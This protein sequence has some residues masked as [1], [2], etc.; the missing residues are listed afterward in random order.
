MACRWVVS[1][2]L[3]LRRWQPRATPAACS[4]SPLFNCFLTQEAMVA[5]NL[6]VSLHYTVVFMDFYGRWKW[7][8]TLDTSPT[9]ANTVKPS[10]Q[11]VHTHTQRI[12]KT[13]RL[14]KLYYSCQ[15][16]SSSRLWQCTWHFLLLLF[17]LLLH[18]SVY[19]ASGWVS[20]IVS[21]CFCLFEIIAHH[22]HSSLHILFLSVIHTRTHISFKSL[23]SFYIFILHSLASYHKL[24]QIHDQIYEPPNM[25]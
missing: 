16:F 22:H 11:N 23:Q 6:S 13:I 2:C 1:D 17:L 7:Y 9:S 10:I 24:L 5:V 3:S 12:Q 8:H 21:L 25:L 18:V 20:F 19:L 14:V 4:L 15:S